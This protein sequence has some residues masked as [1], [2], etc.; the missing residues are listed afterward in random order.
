MKQRNQNGKHQWI[1]PKI[2]FWR[3]SWWFFRCG[4]KYF[5]LFRLQEFCTIQT[6]L[7]NGIWIY[8]NFKH[9]TSKSAI[10]IYVKKCIRASE[11]ILYISINVKYFYFTNPKIYKSNDGPGYSKTR[12][13]PSSHGKLQVKR[14]F[15]SFSPIFCDLF[16][17]FSNKARD[18]TWKKSIEHG[19]KNWMEIEKKILV[20]I[21]FESV[22]G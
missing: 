22:F 18:G 21:V 19:P 10:F 3:E 8:K 11:F 7:Q 13:R 4:W 5:E 9:R 17:C 20:Q 14:G 1:L 6:E 2:I 16:W 12:V 15:S